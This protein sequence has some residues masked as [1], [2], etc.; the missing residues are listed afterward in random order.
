LKSLKGS[1]P[2]LKG[3]TR[4]PYHKNIVIKTT[5]EIIVYDIPKRFSKAYGAFQKKVIINLGLRKINFALQKTQNKFCTP[6]GPS[7][8]IFM[9]LFLEMRPLK[10]SKLLPV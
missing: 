1:I 8:F 5:E 2:S 4:Q 6:F 9:T 3:L 7:K 10:H